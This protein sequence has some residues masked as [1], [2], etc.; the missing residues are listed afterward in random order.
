M[1]KILNFSILLLLSLS[2]FSCQ[3]TKDDHKNLKAINDGIKK[4]YAPD[5]RVA[6]YEIELVSKDG[7]IE[8]IGES[9]QPE[10][11]SANS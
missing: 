11:H 9:D 5:K 1:H 7:S 8:I 10:H 3:K 6:V 2:F 4:F